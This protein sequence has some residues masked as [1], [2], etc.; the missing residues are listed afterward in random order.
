MAMPP[1]EFRRANSGE[2]FPLSFNL[3]SKFFCDTV[4]STLEDE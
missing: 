1:N 3:V 4:R 2:F